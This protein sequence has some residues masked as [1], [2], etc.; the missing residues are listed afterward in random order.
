MLS[1]STLQPEAA[2]LFDAGVLLNNSATAIM[3]AA[4]SA[5]LISTI[6]FIPPPPP[7]PQ[8]SLAAGAAVVPPPPYALSE[9]FNLQSLESATKTIYLDFDGF[10]TRGTAWNFEFGLPNIVTPK[11]SID[12]DFANFSDEELTYIQFIYQ[13]VAEDYRPFNVNVTTKEPL[14]ADL[15]NSG[16]GDERWGIRVVIGGSTNDWYSPTSGSDAGGVAYLQSFNDAEDQPAFVFGGDY[17]AFSKGIAEAVTHEVGHTLGLNHDGQYRFYLDSENNE[18][19]E[20]FYP[21]YYGH[22][23]LSVEIQD[24]DG[25]VIGYSIV[26]NTA[27]TSWAPIMGVGYYEELTQWSIGEY[28]NSNNLEDDLAIITQEAEFFGY[29]NGFGYRPDDYGETAESASPIAFS[30]VGE[31]SDVNTF[32][33]EGLIGQHPAEGVSDV[34]YFSFT[35]DTLGE[36]YFIDVS[37]FE[38]GPNLDILAKIKNDQG[39]VLYTSNPVDELKAGSQTIT[40]TNRDGVVDGG[41]VN[42]NGQRTDE[43]IF[44]PG[45]YY[46]TVEGTGK[47]ITYINPMISPG[48]I[49]DPPGAPDDPQLLPD[50]SDWGYSNYGSLGKYYVTG[51]RKRNLVVGVDFDPNS[52]QHPRN[53]NS[54]T[55]GSSPATLTNLI[56]EAGL[57]VPFQ[58]TVTTSGTTINSVAS[59]NP[60][61]ASNIPKHGIP[62]N[63]VSGYLATTTDKLT[64]EWSHLTPDTV[65]QIYVFGH[66]NAAIHNHVTVVGGTW[67]GVQQISEYEQIVSAGSLAVNG[68]APGNNDLTT[69]SV[70][71]VSDATG[72]IKIDVQGVDG[73]AVGVAGV[74]IA[75]TRVG[76]LSGQ[77]WQDTNGDKVHQSGEPGLESWLIY[78]DVN[79]DGQLN[80]TEDRIL[81]AP[82]LNVPQDL[83]DYST[84]KNELF[85]TEADKITDVNVKLD[86]EHTY[87]ADLNVYLIS[88]AGTRVKLF[89]DIGGP[90][91]NF[92]NTTLDDQALHEIGSSFTSAPFTGSFRPQEA[93]SAFNGE[94]SAGKWTLEINDDATGDTGVLKSWSIELGFAGRYLEPNQVSDENGNF[95]FT[96]VRAG[97]Y[98]VREQFSAEQTAAGW[99][100]SLKPELTP[101]T[102]RSGANVVGVDVGNWI[103]TSQHG[104]IHGTVFNDVN[105]NGA[106]DSGETGLAGWTVYL[107]TNSNDAYDIATTPVTYNSAG[108]AAPIK[109]FNVVN[110]PITVNGVGQVF[111]IEVTLNVTHSYVGDLDAYLL[112]PH[113]RHVE[114]F[115]Q[116]GGQYNDLTNLTLSDS[117][118]RSIADIGFND[119]PY[120]GTWRP[121][122][123]LS[124]FIGETINGT[125]LLQ[126]R[127]TALADEGSLNSWSIKITAGELSQVTDSSGNYEFVDLPAGP[128]FVVREVNQAGWNL[129]DPNP[130]S[131]PPATWSGSEW[132]VPIAAQAN[133]T[134]VNFGN[135][136]AVA[137]VGDYNRSNDVDA[138]D[139]V[140]WRKKLGT[141]VPA[142][143]DGA[144]GNGNGSVDAA[145]YSVWRSNFGVSTP[146]GSGSMALAA[147]GS[148]PAVSPAGIL[149]EGPAVASSIATSAGIWEFNSDLHG[150]DLQLNP[151]P[152]YRPAAF[153][154]VSSDQALLAWLAEAG[155][156]EYTAMDGTSLSPQAASD[157]ESVDSA[158]ESLE[159]GM[160]TEDGVV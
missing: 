26:P 66:S 150:S 105:A 32:S 25:N 154:A 77:K 38:T 27:P 65:Y 132:S 160:L 129:V 74:A 94:I 8:Q 126:I 99:Q 122:G 158:F 89:G 131:N 157:A 46:V 113:G 69:Y 92:H 104:S 79:N 67:N 13:R 134:N 75:A 18:F 85:V 128:T 120:T 24:D 45:T 141:T 114:L 159:D 146:A 149:V 106:K 96:G 56:S 9:T 33:A 47:P 42:T 70:L 30:G 61:P 55:G 22:P 5:T 130:T 109:D 23:E 20:V 148:L 51:T 68:N 40:A 44:A 73:A 2:S 110:S 81:P 108:A 43:L 14:A 101:I 71:V 63:N 88:P 41:W 90:G 35:V 15:M 28:P 155:N 136:A 125:W 156:E 52:N 50:D 10:T 54:Y 121:E 12:T 53:W 7:P 39:Q 144:D 72:K 140:L 80:K 49:V 78:L 84:V 137:L 117:A 95:T 76:T 133:V 93:L 102:V 57:S 11:Y 145:D 58:L 115:T 119:V 116:V 48:P 34:D 118:A 62:L 97:Q 147:S 138:A 123:L 82:A 91:D 112:S 153:V 17:G 87:D 98:Y 151:R 152:A 6:G 142:P 31:D 100:Q 37:P 127:D 124:D 143:Y 60:I 4:G 111:K 36:I 64:F 83:A 86:I 139:F 19:H 107:D 103:P 21:Y 1:A 3:P 59:T 16:N 135:K 29:E